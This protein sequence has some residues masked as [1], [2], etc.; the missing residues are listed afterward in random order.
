ME[1]FVYFAMIFLSIVDDFYLQGILASMKQE[2]WWKKNYPQKLYKDDYIIA[3]GIH[4]FSWSFM[5]Q[6]PVAILYLIIGASENR[7]DI[8]FYV[9]GGN[10]LIHAMVDNL[11]AN[12]KVI[13]LKTDQLIH[14]IQTTVSAIILLLWVL[15]R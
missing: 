14:Y 2:D 13:N 6:L 8:F 15:K 7:W 12:E 3:L 10:T 9:L 5:M 11:K 1:V 4:S